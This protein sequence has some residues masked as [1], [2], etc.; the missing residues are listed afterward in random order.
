MNGHIGAWSE[1]PFQARAAPDQGERFKPAIQ[2][3]TGSGGLGAILDHD[4]LAAN[5]AHAEHDPQRG[6]CLPVDQDARSEK[7][8]E[9]QGRPG[10]VMEGH[11]RPW[12]VMEGSWKVMEG[13]GGS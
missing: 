6:Q 3:M 9:G 5:H 10:K 7:V 13:H 11:G 12:K 8:R 1:S 2:R 4:R